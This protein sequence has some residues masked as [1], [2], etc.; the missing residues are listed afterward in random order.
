MIKRTREW[1]IF[2]N[3]TFTLICMSTKG[4]WEDVAAATATSGRPRTPARPAEYSQKSPRPNAAQGVRNLRPPRRSAAKLTHKKG[5]SVFI[6]NNDIS[7]I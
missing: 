1:A 2:I 3:I 4:H 5:K 6:R 7:V